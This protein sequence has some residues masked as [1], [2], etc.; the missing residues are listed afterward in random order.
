MILIRD[1]ICIF[2]CRVLQATINPCT[3]PD[4]ANTNILPIAGSET[5][6][7]FPAPV[8]IH[9]ICII[10]LSLDTGQ[11]SRKCLVGFISDR[12]INYPQTAERSGGGN[13]G[14]QLPGTQSK[15]QN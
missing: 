6:I 10:L 15:H 14:E 1:K 11:I 9:V 12:D 13:K 8:N 5:I 7:S 2:I 3:V 4:G